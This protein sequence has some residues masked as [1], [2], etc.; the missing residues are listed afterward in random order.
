MILADQLNTLSS[1]TAP[2]LT[3]AIHIAGYKGDSFTTAKFLGMTNG[4]QF[5]YK[6]EYEDEDFGLLEAKVFLSYNPTTGTVEA[7]Y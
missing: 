5:C 6:V 2:A 7:D 3:R 4:N 1:F